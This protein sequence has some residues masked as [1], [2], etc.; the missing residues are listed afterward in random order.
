MKRAGEGGRRCSA[1]GLPAATAAA[2]AAAEEDMVALTY[3]RLDRRA[4]RH[5]ISCR[6]SSYS[7]A[8]P[9]GRAHVTFQVMVVSAKLK[10]G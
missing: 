8:A 2:A 10:S 1:D 9:V 3:V 6:V 5:P 7:V 4:A